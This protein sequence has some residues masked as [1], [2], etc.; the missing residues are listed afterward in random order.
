M[1]TT[2]VNRRAGVD[3]AVRFLDRRGYEI[4]VHRLERNGSEDYIVARDGE[5][6]VFLQ[7]RMSDC[8]QQ[9]LPE[10]ATDESDLE[11]FEAVAVRYLTKHPNLVEVP[12]RFD[13]VDAMPLGMG[14]AF[15]RHHIN[16]FN[17]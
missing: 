16:V 3:A 17:D 9:G 1:A 8:C 15:I 13:R 12:V 10:D 6:L 11:R 2:E 14:R 5:A 7:V 4:L